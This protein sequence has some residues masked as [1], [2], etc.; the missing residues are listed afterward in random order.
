MGDT[1]SNYAPLVAIHPGRGAAV[2]RWSLDGWHLLM[3]QLYSRHQARFIVTG[4]ADETELARQVAS[5]TVPAHSVAGRTSLPVLA[6]LFEQCSLVVGPDSGP[7]HL[8]VAMRRP[9]IHLY[10]PVS[11]ALFGPWGDPAYNVVIH[12]SLACQYCERLDWPESVLHEHPC[13]SGIPPTWVGQA[14]TRLLERTNERS[15]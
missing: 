15:E 4:G 14:A 9:T 13:V 7:L 11:P 10:G 8:A 1:G 12:Q 3:E 6:A 2:K 5:T